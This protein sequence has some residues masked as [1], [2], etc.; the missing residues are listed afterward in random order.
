MTCAIHTARF[1][2]STGEKV[3]D[4][5]VLPPPATDTAPAEMLP[6]LQKAGRLS[7]PIRTHNCPHYEVLVEGEVVK[8][9]LEWRDRGQ[10]T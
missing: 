7:S 5:V 9:R 10:R 3:A 2:V 6:Y 4:A 8:V 1:D